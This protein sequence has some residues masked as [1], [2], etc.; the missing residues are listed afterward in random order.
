MPPDPLPLVRA[1]GTHSEVGAQIGSASA[2]AVARTA[3]AVTDEELAAA[4]PYREVTARELPWLVEELDAV[5]DGAGADRMRVF[6]ASIEELASL[7]GGDG[8][9]SDMVAR[10]RPSAPSAAV[11]NDVD[12]EKKRMVPDSRVTRIVPS[13][14]PGTFTRFTATSASRPA[15]SITAS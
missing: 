13:S 2:S 15:A 14:V 5:A 6:A 9:C 3:A 4:R 12:I 1:A 11:V 8:A 7:D 10:P